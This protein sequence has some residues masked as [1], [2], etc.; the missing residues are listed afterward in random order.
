MSLYCL[1]SSTQFI[2]SATTQS[3]VTN[4][5]SAHAKVTIQPRVSILN[6]TAQLFKGQPTRNQ[7]LICLKKT[8]QL[9]LW[10]LP[11]ATVNLYLLYLLPAM[12]PFYYCQQ[13]QWMY[14]SHTCQ[15]VV[16]A[17][18]M[19]CSNT[20]VKLIIFQCHKTQSNLPLTWS[21][22]SHKATILTQSNSVN[23]CSCHLFRKL[24]IHAQWK[25]LELCSISW[26]AH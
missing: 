8:N 16:I 26:S 4:C 20:S 5:D 15:K 3:T 1:N 11:L 25:W 21:I 17:Q 7:S 2:V 18:S 12:I 9:C 14:A 10:N 13:A 24:L 19:I 22:R 6:Q 23:V